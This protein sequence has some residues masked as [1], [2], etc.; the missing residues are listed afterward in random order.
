MNRKILFLV[1]ILALSSAPVFITGCSSSEEQT[2]ASVDDG[3]DSGE[4][5]EDGS[6]PENP[7]ADADVSGTPVEA[8]PPADAAAGGTDDIVADLGDDPTAEGDQSANALPDQAMGGDAAPP[9]DTAVADNNVPPPA[10]AM[11][12]GPA[13]DAP[14]PLGAESDMPV[15]AAGPKASLKKVKDTPFKSNGRI[16]NTVYVARKGDTTAKV[17]EKVFGDKTRKKELVADNSMLGGGRG[18][19]EGD[20]IYYNSPRRPDD[21]TT[22]MTYYE[23]NGVPAQSYVAKDGDDL[24]KVAKEILGSKDGWKELWVTNPNLESKGALSGGTEIR[25]WTAAPENVAV[26]PPPVAPPA[27]QPPPPALG[28]TAP[29]PP[30]LNNMPPPSDSLPPPPPPPPT[31]DM[32]AMP[33][34]PPPPPDVNQAATEFPPPPPPPGMGK[35]PGAGPE[36]FLF[37]D[38]ETTM[39]LGAG[40]IILLSVLMVVV[41]RIKKGRAQR[42]RL[43]QTQV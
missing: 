29:P 23:D 25:Y 43:G 30:D 36:A 38:Q 28:T 14:P 20:K 10:D 33:P 22:M 11:D 19:K 13:P 24:K 42:M 32:N 16:L 9:P 27:D 21:T 4:L 39:A 2:E 41:H 15:A 6:A 12:S 37:A 17:A 1:S 26:A 34:P 31:Q 7:S 8:T 35:K 18:V 40:A 5:S 3:V